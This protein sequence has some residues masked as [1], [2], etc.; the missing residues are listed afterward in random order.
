MINYSLFPFAK[1]AERTQP[2][3]SRKRKRTWRAKQKKYNEEVPPVCSICGT[4]TENAADGLQPS[5]LSHVKH[6]G[7][8][9]TWDEAI[10]DETNIL[11]VCN[12]CHGKHPG[13]KELTAATGGTNGH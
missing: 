9:G 5:N 13:K 4:N 11:P 2:K 3:R 1:G 8:G 6:R 7:M 10:N 12:E